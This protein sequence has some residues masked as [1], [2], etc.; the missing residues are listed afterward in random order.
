MMTYWSV[1]IPAWP[2]VASGMMQGVGLAFMFLP[3]NLISFAT[4]PP[5]LR[6][7]ATSLS[8]LA[9][10]LGSSFGI[11]AMIVLLSRS[12]Q[13][14]HAEIGQS[15]ARQAIPVDVDRLAAFGNVSA[16]PFAILDGMVNR[17]AAMI[18][19]INDFQV[20]AMMCFAAL[21]LLLLVRV[22]AP[23]GRAAAPQP[24]VDVGH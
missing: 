11:A 9:R 16:A 10:N 19:Y 1:D 5:E 21:P 17:Q 6:T 8:S 20:V 18:G 7:D 15:I 2:I 24:A 4:L 3:L 13:T 22:K 14:S 12:I 23:A